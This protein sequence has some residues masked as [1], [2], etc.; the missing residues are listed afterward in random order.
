MR[1]GKSHGIVTVRLFGI[2]G[3]EDKSIDKNQTV[4]HYL[5][6][7]FEGELLSTH[8]TTSEPHYS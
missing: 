2:A 4:C 1:S 3:V 7:K 8:L 6:Y 5:C